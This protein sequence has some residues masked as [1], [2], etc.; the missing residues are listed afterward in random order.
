FQAGVMKAIYRF[1]VEH[2]A[3]HKVEVIA[4]TSIGSWNALFW[5]GDLIMPPVTAAESA[6]AKPDLKAGN[7]RPPS[8]SAAANRGRWKGESIHESWWRSISAKTL[9]APSAYFPFF[10]N[11]FLSS[12]PWQMVFEQIFEQDDVKK[13]IHKSK[14]KFYMTRSNVRT[15]E[16][17]CA[18]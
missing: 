15:G 11:A 7:G 14:I 18:T 6:V 12:M 5:L 1:L 17:E 3:L 4:S 2:D 16:L 9:V 13:R 10:F 8:Q